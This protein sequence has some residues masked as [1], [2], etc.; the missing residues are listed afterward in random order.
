MGAQRGRPSLFFLF[1]GWALRNHPPPTHIPSAEPICGCTIPR[2]YICNGVRLAIDRLAPVDTRAFPN[3]VARRCSA[4]SSVRHNQRSSASGSPPEGMGWVGGSPLPRRRRGRWTRVPPA[5]ASKGEGRVRGVRCAFP[6]RFA[7]ARCNA[8]GPRMGL[9]R[10]SDKLQVWH[11][12]P[13]PPTGRF[14]VPMEWMDGW[15]NE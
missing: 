7:R 2:T 8:W 11:L 1:S 13:V 14:D 10:C 6:D 4:K 12:L 3:P 5:A 15:M 9:G